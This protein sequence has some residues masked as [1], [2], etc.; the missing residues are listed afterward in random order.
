[1]DFDGTLVDFQLDP[2]AVLLPPS[3]QV[4]LNTL[5]TRADLSAGIVT[6][7][8][9]SDVR[10]RVPANHTLFFAGLHGLEIEG[11]GLRFVHNAISL[12]TPAVSLLAKDLRRAVK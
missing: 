9:V 2:D 6:G 8:R 11:P 12:A 5:S 1:M 4:L 7:R 3:R 10:Q